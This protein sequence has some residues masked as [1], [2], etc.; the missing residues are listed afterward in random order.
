MRLDPSSLPARWSVE[1]DE[2]GR[3][4]Q[5]ASLYM[6]DGG[7]VMKRRLSGLPLTL[8]LPFE[9][10]QGVAVRLATDAD[11]DLT[12]HVEL[13]HHDPALSVPLTVTRNMEIAAADWQG[14][15]DRLHLPMLLIERDGAAEQVGPRASVEIGAPVPRRSHGATASRR[16][17][18]LMRRKVG[19]T[20]EMPVLRG[21]REIISYE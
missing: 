13:H 14:W 4:A 3:Q 9:A 15:S 2:K 21:C 5:E 20:G 8:S 17:R 18:F 19:Q 7:I 10:F 11:G 16:P 6:D 12:A 1:V